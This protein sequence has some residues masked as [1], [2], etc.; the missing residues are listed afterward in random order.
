MTQSLKG[1]K[2]F[3]VVLC[4]FTDIPVPS[5]PNSDIVNFVMRNGGGGLFDYWR[6]VSYGQ[7]SLDGSE[8]FGWYTMQYSWQMNSN[9]SRNIWI[10]EARRLAAE[11]HVDLSRFYGV[12]A[13]VNAE[14]DDSANG[15]TDLAVALRSERQ[16]YG[17]QW[18]RKC[19]ALAYAG[20]GAGPCIT[21][22]VH[23]HAGDYA[24]SLND[25]AFT[26]Q[27]G[28]RWCQK[29]QALAYAGAGTVGPCVAGGVHDHSTSGLYRVGM[30]PVGFRGQ[31]QWKWCRKCQSISYVGGGTVGPCPAG[32]Q[33]D[34]STSANYSL[35]FG[36]STLNITFIAHE[37]GHALGLQ[38]SWS[39]H[40]DVEYGDPWDIMS[41]FSVQSS[42]SGRYSPIGPGLNAPTLNRLG[43]L[44]EDRVLTHT[45][46]HGFQFPATRQI[47]LAALNRPE[48]N[49]PLMIRVLTPDRIYT[50]E[51]RQQ[52][53][54]DHGMQQPDAVFIHELRSYYTRSQQNWRWC[55]N[56]EGLH[57]AGHLCCPA[58]GL[59]DLG[60]TNYRLS[61]DRPDTGGQDNWRWCRKCQLLAYAGSALPG[62]CPAGGTHD[63]AASGDYRLVT[64]GGGQDQWK[65]CRKC[66][67]LTYAGSASLNACSAGGVH[68]TSTSSNYVIPHDTAGA[69]QDGWRWCRKCQG[70]A[71][72]MR[73][74]CPAGGPHA[75][76]G[77]GDYGLTNDSSAAGND[78]WLWCSKCMGLAF[79]KNG[80]AGA[81]P[82]GGGH[83]LTHSM[84]YRLLPS[85][86]T[87]A[88]GQSEWRRCGKCEGL[89]Y[90]PH[91]ATSRC[92]AGGQHAA[93]EQT[94]YI[95]ANLDADRTYLIQREWMAP[96]R[97]GDA[98]RDITIT[99]DAFDH[100]AGVATIGLSGY[101]ATE[102]H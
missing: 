22:G 45:P 83:D 30:G 4:K 18:C 15:T 38:H 27:P 9:V 46:G 43:W 59:H 89:Y 49:L 13:V 11:N 79:G 12:I 75:W 100:T 70:M 90:G 81:C 53:G 85:P 24:L 21:G 19:Q 94:T 33:H 71:Y 28:W 35:A 25:E 86:G 99:V 26:G 10:A 1:P 66:Q 7:I 97:F 98:A 32:G 51:F 84:G 6:D 62:A 20:R 29:C 34:P 78:G 47:Q 67:G 31:D 50:V 14:A 96:S 37:S 77:S 92:P 5:V 16:Q 39:A 72:S 91:A 88:N 42:P 56:C 65:W 54:W 74:V 93:A 40:P 48:I 58:G 68:D 23:D 82:G 101:A 95:L 8:V 60:L 61:L 102:H 57:Y 52:A 55:K 44:G 17:W 41:A 87:A 3:A 69:G 73:S 36:G 76:D 80:S 2:P 63:H 64:A